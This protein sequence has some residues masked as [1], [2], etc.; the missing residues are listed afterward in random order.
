M[1]TYGPHAIHTPGGPTQAARVAAANA[2]GEG[3]DPE[4]CCGWRPDG[5]GGG[6][7]FPK[8]TMHLTPKGLMCEDC[9]KKSKY[10]QAP[11][12]DKTK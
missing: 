11:E 6:E 4:Q 3:A 1:P 10:Y 5:L 7:I 8:N 12:E 9:W 2:A